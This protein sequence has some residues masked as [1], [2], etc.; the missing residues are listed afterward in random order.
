MESSLFLPTCIE[1]NAFRIRIR[2]VSDYRHY[3][4]MTENDDMSTSHSESAQDGTFTL[5]HWWNLDWLMK[6]LIKARTY[7][8]MFVNRIAILI[9]FIVVLFRDCYFFQ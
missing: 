7:L 4:G 3:I 1:T 9:V 5:L 6:R 8:V 2:L